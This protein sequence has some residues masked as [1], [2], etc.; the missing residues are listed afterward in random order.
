MMHGAGFKGLPEIGKRHAQTKV[1][2][3]N[4]N[5]ATLTRLL[6]KKQKQT[7]VAVFGF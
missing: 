2:G 1:L 3:E 6:R 7:E 4:H 5:L